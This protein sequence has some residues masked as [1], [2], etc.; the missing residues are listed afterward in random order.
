MRPPGQDEDH[1]EIVPDLSAIRRLVQDWNQA[2]VPT[3]L[4]VE[5]EVIELPTAVSLASFRIVQE[6]LTNVVRHAENPTTIVTLAYT[7][8]SLMIDVHNT[9][10]SSSSTFQEGG[11]TG[12]V[13]I[14]ERVRSLSG[15][16]T[17]S[18]LADGGFRIEA[19]LPLHAERDR[20]DQPTFTLSDTGHSG[21]SDVDSRR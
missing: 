1:G 13:G 15:A 5:G 14:R 9:T 6:A 2:G 21:A 7:P 3:S 4:V 8:T 10:T 19:V 20:D 18:P 11:G 17:A 16:F 12:L